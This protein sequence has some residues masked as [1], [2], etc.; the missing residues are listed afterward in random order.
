MK[1]TI[2]ALVIV[3]LVSTPC[4]AE[5]E[6]KGFSSLDGTVWRVCKITL[7]YPAKPY[8]SMNCNEELG[9][10]LGKIY[11]YDPN[12]VDYGWL[13]LASYADLGVISIGWDISR[14]DYYSAIMQPTIG[15]GAFTDGWG[16]CACL[17][18]CVC[19]WGYE[20]GIMYKM[21]DYWW[22][23]IEVTGIWGS[24]GTDVYAIGYG[25]I[26]H[27]DGTRWSSM[28]SGVN[29]ALNAIWGSSGTD[30][31]A[32][33]EAII[34]YDGKT[35]SSMTSGTSNS[36]QGIWGSSATD[37]FAAGYFNTILRYDGSTWSDMTNDD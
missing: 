11:S 24:S 36:L 29:V 31:F 16:G 5:V 30:V 6:P 25:S 2:L 8:L 20:I 23:P 27:Y 15:F 1:R 10:D 17:F 22:R 37:V 7:T 26:L 13:Q 4:L 32:V 19:S 28:K 12:H 18:N 35:W 21:D 33:G 3:V 34:H 9:F 14:G